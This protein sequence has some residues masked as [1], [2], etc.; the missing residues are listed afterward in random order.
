MAMFR[1][2]L[3]GLSRKRIYNRYARLLCLDYQHDIIEHSLSQL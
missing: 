1:S 2:E 3:I